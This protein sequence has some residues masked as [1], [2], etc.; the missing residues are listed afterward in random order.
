[1]LNGQRV[2]LCT[3]LNAGESPTTIPVTINWSD[4][5]NAAGTAA[6]SAPIAV[7]LQTG[8]V[9]PI[10]G[11]RSIRIDNIGAFSSCTV[12]FPD[13]GD[14]II[15]PADN[16]VTANVETGQLNCFVNMPIQTG[17]LGTQ[18]RIFFNNFMSYDSEFGVGSGVSLFR[19][20]GAPFSVNPLSPK[21]IGDRWQTVEIPDLTVTG[22]PSQVS[23]FGGPPNGYNF[24]SVQEC[25][26]STI[27]NYQDTFNS[28]IVP[29]NCTIV[30][31]LGAVFQTFRWYPRNDLD[32]YDYKRRYDMIDGQ[33]PFNASIGA[34][35]NRKYFVQNNVA[36]NG[37]A[38]FEFVYTLVN[39]TNNLP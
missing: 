14:E 17:N 7:N 25:H 9:N 18:T 26:F 39:L 11:I 27:G 23:I 16:V 33:I 2:N 38:V 12:F 13:T 37:R 15:C 19:S 36:T 10:S 31:D 21:A 22:V 28:V 35:V 6:P 30:D 8:I 20:T 24:I 1:L 4:Y 29:C 5:I 34:G 32:E 3:P